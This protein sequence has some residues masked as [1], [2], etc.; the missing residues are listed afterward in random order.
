M[1]SL[2]KRFLDSYL[3]ALGAAEI[4]NYE[5]TLTS[6]SGTLR[7]APDPERPDLS[8][9]LDYLEDFRWDATDADVPDEAAMQI[10]DL[11]NLRMLLDIDTLRLSRTELYT[12]M[13]AETD[14]P[15]ER[16][17]FEQAL[18][19]LEDVRVAIIED[20]EEVDHFAIHA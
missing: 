13:H 9:D 5:E 2:R 1:T 6:A 15:M 8:G 7:Y 3:G 12:F 19:E 4:L 18:S 10:L 20:G 17:V 14:Q 16:L 11:I